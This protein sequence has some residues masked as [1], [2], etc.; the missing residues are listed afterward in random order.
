M[1]SKKTGGATPEPPAKKKPA[2]PKKKAAPKATA[3]KAAA[4]KAP[5][6]RAPAK[7]APAKKT[8]AK[9]A[10]AVKKAPAAKKAT[11]KKPSVKKADRSKP[12]EVQAAKKKKP[13]SSAAKA[14]PAAA[15]PAVVAPPR[16]KSSKFNPTAVVKP[17]KKKK[18]VERKK[19]KAPVGRRSASHQDGDA[20]AGPASGGGGV[21]GGGGFTPEQLRR[22]KTGIG[23]RK[24]AAFREALL[25]HRRELL[26][27][28]A[29]IDAARGGDDGD[30]HVPLH[31]ADVGSEN[32]EKEFNL[33]LQETERKLLLDIDE[34]LLRIRD[35]TYGVC[36]ETGTPIGEARLEI[37]PW[38]RYG[39]EAMTRRESAGLEGR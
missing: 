11:T 14:A 31:M 16:R 4:K 7:K 29:G 32:Y 8:P 36:L 2:A 9:K 3:S 17:V 21:S 30:S 10:G 38:A 26:A 18:P 1:P 13:A 15:E 39:I 6:K 27:D 5:G 22:V 20:P 33:M 28:V 25:E 24:L 12:L 23:K 35:G 34:A 37:K 19:Y